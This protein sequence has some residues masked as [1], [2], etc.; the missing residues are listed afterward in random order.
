MSDETTYR[1][2]NVEGTR[3]VAEAAARSGSVARLVF[4]SSLAAGGPAGLREPR[5]ESR[6]DA[7]RTGYGRSKLAAEQLLR[8]GDWPFSSVSLRPPSLYGPRDREF[9]PLL[10]AA[11]RGWTGH[12]GKRM[13]GL[14]LVHGRDAATA[15]VAL[16]ETA[17]AAGHYYVDDGPGHEGPREP[18]RRW[19]WGYD[20]HELRRVLSLLF[21][22]QL[23]EIVIPLG[24]LRVVSRLVPERTRQSSPLLNRDRMH[25]LDVDGWVCGSARL[26]R[27]TGWLPEWNLASGMRD[28]LA[29]YRRR[30]WL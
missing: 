11:N 29:F 5:D 4:V 28:T 1:R 10:R 3:L 13:Q 23:R 2:V 24:V 18:G 21:D 12:V 17:S 25:D 27:D 26:R 8:E 20:W 16:L 22:R 19:P 30:G 7:P 9:R 6:P 14:S 15:A